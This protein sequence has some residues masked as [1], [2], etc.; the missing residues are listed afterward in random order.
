MI[1]ICARIWRHVHTIL[2]CGPNMCQKYSK[3]GLSFSEH[4]VSVATKSTTRITT[5]G[6]T[7]DDIVRE[8][9]HAMPSLI[10]LA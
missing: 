1:G 8:D 2:R 3:L 7:T 10:S 4:A 9:A 6:T 5:I